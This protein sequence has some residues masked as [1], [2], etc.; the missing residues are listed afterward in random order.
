MFIKSSIFSPAP[1]EE[2]ILFC[3][4][5][6]E[7]ITAQSGRGCLIILVQKSDAFFAFTKDK[8]TES[9]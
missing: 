8:P 2:Q 7:K 5:S 6:A 4:G 9:A 3:W 1:I